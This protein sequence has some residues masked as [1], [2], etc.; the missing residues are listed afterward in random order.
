MK[1]S[2]ARDS[3]IGNEALS[4]L[5][6]LHDKIDNAR[7]DQERQTII[8]GLKDV[9][10]TPTTA[11]DDLEPPERVKHRGCPKGSNRSL[12]SDPQ[13]KKKKKEKKGDDSTHGEDCSTVQKGRKRQTSSSTASSSKKTD[14]EFDLKQ[15]R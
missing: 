8:D 10:D 7:D 14:W 9:L 11:L 3:I 6:Q 4:L 12:P 1:N 13:E 15:K 5:Y 2:N